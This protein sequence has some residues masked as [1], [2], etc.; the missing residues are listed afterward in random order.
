MRPGSK[1]GKNFYSQKIVS[2]N[3]FKFASIFKGRPS[4]KIINVKI[5][6]LFEI[7]LEN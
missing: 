6:R 3:S 5:Q 7:I 1:I 4:S 2:T